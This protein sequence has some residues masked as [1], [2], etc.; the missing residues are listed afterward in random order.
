MCDLTSPKCWLVTLIFFWVLWVILRENGC[1]HK[2]NVFGKDKSNIKVKN[3]IIIK[4]VITTTKAKIKSN[5]FILF[6]VNYL[7]SNG[8]SQNIE[9]SSAV[10]VFN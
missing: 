2:K 8:I 7:V 3:G 10:L 6:Y 1:L 4:I 5:L 9:I